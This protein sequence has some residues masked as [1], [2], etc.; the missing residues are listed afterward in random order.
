MVGKGKTYGAMSKF[1]VICGGAAFLFS[2]VAIFVIQL[3]GWRPFGF[4]ERA[5]EINSIIV[6]L[7]YSYLAAVIFYIIVNYLPQIHRHKIMRH[8]IKSY[9]IRMKNTMQRC[10]K[11]INLYS[12]KQNEKFPSKEHFIKQFGEKDLAPPC[13][14]LNILERNRL[15]INLLMDFLLTVQ[16]F[17][18]DNEVRMLLKLKD[19]MFLTQPLR[20]KD[21]VEGDNGEKCEIPGSNQIEMAESI[22]DVYEQLIKLNK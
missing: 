11:G 9:L 2:M 4:A 20:P 1:S 17:L 10:I 12:L 5:D 13:D 19:S 3:T 21:Y 8:M 18:S 14:Y 7:S 6:N 22:Y 15:E 16:E